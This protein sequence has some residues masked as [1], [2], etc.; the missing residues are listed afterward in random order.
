MSLGVNSTDRKKHIETLLS[1][2]SSFGLYDK[3][4]LSVD[5]YDEKFSP[6][7]EG[8][9]GD[10]TRRDVNDKKWKFNNKKFSHRQVASVGR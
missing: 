2:C 5:L 6:L 4:I 9:S 10:Q 8:K 1:N 3:V 7:C